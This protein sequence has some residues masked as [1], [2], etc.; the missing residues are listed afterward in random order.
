MKNVIYKISNTVNDKI[1][2]GSSINFNNRYRQHRFLLLNKKHFNL[3]IQ[4][5]VNKYGFESLIFTVLESDCDNLIFREQYF[6]DKLKPCFNIRTIAENNKGLKRTDEQKKRQSIIS[7]E[8]IKKNK[9]FFSKESKSKAVNTRKENGGYIV[10]EETKI[11]ISNST[12]GIKKLSEE[13]KLK[14]SIS[15]T[16]RIL[17]ESTKILL[18]NQKKGCLNPMFNKKKELH[19]NFGK[20]WINSKKRNSKKVIDTCTGVIYESVLELSKEINVPRSTLNK[21]VN[22][23]IKSKKRYKYV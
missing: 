13:T 11:K 3:K 7:K 21:W 15:S 16:G 20:K 12:K 14:I 2:I 1:Y 8:N 5:H 23:N 10:S 17:S 9:N 19:H 6:I 22:G 18:S 4:N